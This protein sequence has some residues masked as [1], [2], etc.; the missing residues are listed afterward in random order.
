MILFI[1]IIQNFA[2]IFKSLSLFLLIYWNLRSSFSLR[3]TV[4]F[5]LILF[6][7]FASVLIFPF[8]SS[9]SPT[10]LKLHRFGLSAQSVISSCSLQPFSYLPLRPV[11]HFR[12]RIFHSENSI[13]C[14]CHQCIFNY[15][16]AFLAEFQ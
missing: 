4:F 13:V 11:D 10:I 9:G 7:V 1:Y 14:I 2:R 3:T 15:T 5:P 8:A 12:V 16:T 6:L